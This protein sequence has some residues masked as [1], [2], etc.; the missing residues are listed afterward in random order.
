I[1]AVVERSGAVVIDYRST[2][3]VPQNRGPTNSWEQSMS[4]LTGIEM[5]LTL[6][7]DA[8]VRPAPVRPSRWSRLRRSLRSNWQLY[9]LAA[10]ALIFF[11]IFNYVP[12]YGAQIAFKDFI[13]SHGI[14]GSDWTDFKNF[15]RF[16]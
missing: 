13:A 14:W 4:S 1:I 12:M 8:T 16:L 15:Y 5:T 11:L 10:P 9:L 6:P 3:I 7:E 2:A